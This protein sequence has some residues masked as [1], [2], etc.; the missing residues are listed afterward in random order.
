MSRLDRLVVPR[1]EGLHGLDHLGVCDVD[2]FDD[3]V[4]HLSLRSCHHLG[5]GGAFREPVHRVDDPGRAPVGPVRVV[6]DAGLNVLLDEREHVQGEVVDHGRGGR[7]RD[8]SLVDV[9][10]HHE[11]VEGRACADRGGARLPDH[12]AGVEE[13]QIDNVLRSGRPYEHRIGKTVHYCPPV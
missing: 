6:R 10:P 13:D 11:V 9:R 7:D 1:D 5:Q 2:P 4:V 12:V 3:L 8:R